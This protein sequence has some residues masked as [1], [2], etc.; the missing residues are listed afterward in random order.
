[1]S[2]RCVLLFSPLI[3]YQSTFLDFSDQRKRETTMKKKKNEYFVDRLRQWWRGT[4]TNTHATDV[5][6]KQG[7]EKYL[8]S[9]YLFEYQRC[10]F[11]LS[12]S[13]SKSTVNRCVDKVS[14]GADEFF[15]K[16]QRKTGVEEKR[17]DDDDD[18]GPPKR[19]E[20]RRLNACISSLRLRIAAFSFMQNY[21]KKSRGEKETLLL[22]H[23]ML[24]FFRSC[25]LLVLSLSLAYFIFS[26]F[27]ILDYPCVSFA[28]CWSVS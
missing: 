9:Q 12:L 21:V 7:K 28:N 17:G 23:E 6:R 1:M 19:Y 15:R 18:A 13:L 11:C 27:W 22:T 26:P 25:C 5:A 14:A 2:R 8:P 3:I 24:F 4:T 16:V 10:R 20:R